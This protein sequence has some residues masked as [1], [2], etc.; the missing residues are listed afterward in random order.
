M[1]Q[2]LRQHIEQIVKLTEEEWQ[3]VQTYF[4]YRKYKKHQFIVQENENVKYIYWVMSGLAR[5]YQSEESGKEHIL[6]FATKNWWIT[7]Y[8]AYFGENKSSLNID[9]LEDTEVLCLSLENREKLCS[10]ITKMETFFRKK[11][12]MGYMALQSRILSLLNSNPKERYEQFLELYPNLIPRISK[13]LIASYLGVSR[14]TLSRI[15]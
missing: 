12:V 1:Y 14:E 15:S 10:E 13:T 4:S 7:D 2:E 11:S 6:Q 9:C 3:I 8:R 5:L